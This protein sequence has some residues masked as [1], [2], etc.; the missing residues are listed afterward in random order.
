MP[1]LTNPRGR[2]GRGKEQEPFLRPPVHPVRTT[3]VPGLALRRVLPVPLALPGG[4]PPLPSTAASGSPGSKLPRAGFGPGGSD[5][6]PI[7]RLP[8]VSWSKAVL[9]KAGSCCPRGSAQVSPLPGVPFP[10]TQHAGGC[11]PGGIGRAICKVIKSPWRPRD[12]GR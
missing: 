1:A 3:G 11:L 10:L 2:S 8:W 6:S 5:P 7:P 4:Q 12:Y 9:E